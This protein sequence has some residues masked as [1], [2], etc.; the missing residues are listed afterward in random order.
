M[1]NLN[2]LSSRRNF[3]RVSSFALGSLVLPKYK[4][5]EKAKLGH[6]LAY[7][8]RY[9]KESLGVKFTIVDRKFI[10][11]SVRIP[12]GR[13]IGHFFITRKSTSRSKTTS[14]SKYSFPI[15]KGGR[16]VLF[17]DTKSGSLKT[18]LNGV[19]LSRVYYEDGA[20]ESPSG[21]GFWSWVGDLI[22]DI[23]TGIAA[24]LTLITGDEGTFKYSDGGTTTVEPGKMTYDNGYSGFIAEPGLEGLPGVWY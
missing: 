21:Q 23:A 18:S 17:I 11:A 24:Q 12:E 20:G 6:S 7:K 1:E 19:D 15:Q 2:T 4:L 16:D 22:N 9:G 8:I 3:C 13:K 5:W 10:I 14:K